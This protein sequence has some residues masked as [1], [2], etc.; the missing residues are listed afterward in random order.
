[1]A[2]HSF[3][4]DMLLIGILSLVSVLILNLAGKITLPLFYK[5]KPETPYYNFFIESLTGFIAIVTV[6][7]IVI[8]GVY[9][10]NILSVMFFVCFVINKKLIRKEEMHYRFVAY[11]FSKLGFVFVIPFVSLLLLQL[12]PANESI[13]SDMSF[14][15]RISESFSFIKKENFFHFFNGQNAEFDGTVPY[16][17]N[18]FYFASLL[19]KLFS[20]TGYSDMII[21]KHL[22]YNSL[23]SIVFVG[24][25]AF[26]EKFKKP[27]IIEFLLIVLLASIDFVSITDYDQK[28]YPLYTSMWMRPNFTVYYLFLIGIFNFLFDKNYVAASVMGFLFIISNAVVAPPLLVT[29]GGIQLY[30]LIRK[31][32][33]RRL[34]THILLGTLVVTVSIAAFYK[35]TGAGPNASGAYSLSPLQMFYK[36]IGIWKAIAGYVLSLSARVILLLFI[37][38]LPVM[39]LGKTAFVNYMKSNLLFVCFVIMLPLSGIIIFQSLAYLDNMYQFPYVGYTACYLLFIFNVFYVLPKESPLAKKAISVGITSV[40]IV[41]GIYSKSKELNNK[42]VFSEPLVKNDLLLFGLSYAAIEQL[43]EHFN[44]NS[45]L[46]GATVLNGFD[47]KEQYMGYRQSL[48]AQLGYYLMYLQNNTNIELLTDPAV[49]YPDTDFTSKDYTK[50]KGFNQ[51]TR[52]Y[53][54]Y[55]DDSSYIYNLKN[56][57]DLNKIDYLVL[58]KREKADSLKGLSIISRI[59]DLSTGHQFLFLK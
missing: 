9:T 36:T 15:C 46:K 12:M 57:I 26:A 17:Y 31:K 58:S 51:L 56:Y 52:F 34:A 37:A 29:S 7:S 39:V 49:L 19:F 24:L 23:K 48:T 54:N 44:K 30:I 40:L 22:M 6:Y 28:S 1:M 8:F 14:Y 32:A 47:I 27:G 2:N 33:N 5:A 41:A 20:W 38:C 59:R 43:T 18:E 13:Q 4:G 55:V 45:A 11:D 3:F 42:L 50:A 21:F 25:L 10:L 53:T 16:H 35:I